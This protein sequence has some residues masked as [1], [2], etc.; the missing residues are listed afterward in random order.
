MNKIYKKKDNSLK[1]QIPDIQAITQK[2][3]QYETG[4]KGVSFK[5]TNTTMR[6]SNEYD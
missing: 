4:R 1:Q 3:K 6:V 2:E 5:T